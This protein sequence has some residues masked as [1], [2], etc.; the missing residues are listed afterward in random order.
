MNISKEQLA[1]YIE[2]QKKERG[3]QLTEKEAMNEAS[4]L[5]LFVEAIYKLNPTLLKRPEE[6]IKKDTNRNINY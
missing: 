3:I 6:I 2:I 1:K 4:S 5:L